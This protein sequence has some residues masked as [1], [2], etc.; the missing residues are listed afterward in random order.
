MG[1]GK[2]MRIQ[3]FYNGGAELFPDLPILVMDYAIWQYVFFSYFFRSNLFI[4]EPK[5]ENIYMGVFSTHFVPLILK[6]GA[7]NNVRLK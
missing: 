1:F 4:F 5:V 7:K 3:V 6:F 2:H